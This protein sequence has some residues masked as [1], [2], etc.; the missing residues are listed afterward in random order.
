[1]TKLSIRYSLRAQQEEM[2][3]LEYVLDQFGERKAQE[4][5]SRIEK[6]LE[7]ISATPEMYKASEKRKNLLKKYC[8]KIYF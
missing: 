8:P 1:M 7:Q 6:L 3:L 4:I 5:Y 2:D